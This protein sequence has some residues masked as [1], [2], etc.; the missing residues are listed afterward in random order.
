MRGRID[1]RR[2]LT[3]F[4]AAID[5]VG[6]GLHRAADPLPVVRAAQPGRIHLRRR[7]DGPAPGP[8]RAG[9][10]VVRLRLPARQPVR[11]ARRAVAAQRAA[12]G[13]WFKVR[14]DTRTHDILASARLD[15]A[16]R[17]R[18]AVTQP[19]R[20]PDGGIVD[21]DAAARVRLRRRRVTRATP[22]TRSPRRCS[23][24]ACTSSAAAS[25]IT[26]RA[27]SSA[28]A[29]R[30]RMRW[31]SSRAARA[32]SPTSRATT[33][34]LYD[35]LV[36]ASQNRWPSLRFDVGALNDALSRAASRPAST[37]RRSCGRPTPRWW[38]RYEH[39]IRRAAG[40][41]PRGDASPIPTTTSTSTRIATCW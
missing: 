16:L 8:R 14:R 24:T 22:A 5:S 3:R 33:L 11:A 4:A 26:G 17:R 9:S 25:S 18:R 23:P 13:S 10:G 37:T 36:A 15:E 30:S 20:L 32:P 41:G 28:P 7:R 38:L 27:A 2:T 6:R 19:F 29:P 40:H 35:G 12:A 31:C 1:A 21:R 39:V 34:E